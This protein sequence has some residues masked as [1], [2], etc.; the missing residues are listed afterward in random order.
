METV[1][2]GLDEKLVQS[3]AVIITRGL[4][5]V[6]AV[7]IFA[8]YNNVLRNRVDELLKLALRVLVILGVHE[9]TYRGPR[10]HNRASFSE[11]YSSQ[12]PNDPTF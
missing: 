9:L 11:C 5:G 7:P 3:Q 8:E 12:R 10:C 6:N 2:D 1:G 4:I